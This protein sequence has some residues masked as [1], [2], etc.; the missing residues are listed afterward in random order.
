MADIDSKEVREDGPGPLMG[1]LPN[2]QRLELAAAGIY[3]VVDLYRAKERAEELGK[4]D[5]YIPGLP[6][7]AGGTDP[8]PDPEPE[9][10]PEALKKE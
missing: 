1:Y 10:E 2:I 9:P 7:D 3:S 5:M 6:V 8:E 4:G